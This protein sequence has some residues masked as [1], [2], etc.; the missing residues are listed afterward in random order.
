MRTLTAD[1]LVVLGAQDPEM[2]AIEAALSQADIQFAYAAVGPTRCGAGS[3][4]AADS[5]IRIDRNG[6]VSPALVLPSQPLVFVECRLNQFPFVGRID[7]HHE[8]DPGFACSPADY[9]SGSSLGQTLQALGQTPDSTQR[10]LCAADHCLTAAYQGLCPGVD[11][12]ELL[13]M[14]AAWRAL[15]SKQPLD[16]VIGLIL[17]S[18][19]RIE[20]RFDPS[21][22]EAVFLDPTETPAEL[23]EGAAYAGLPVRYRTLSGQ[24]GHQKECLKGASSPRIQAFIDQH[25][26]AGRRAYGNP[27][28]GYAGV[29][30]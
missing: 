20:D 10:L 28:R 5:V 14:R 9:L 26:A 3:A 30:L 18:A 24:G 21:A 22:G 19:K 16:H 2:R 13:F 17:D 11:P 25:R 8:G 15:L 4:Y 29:Y 7:H 1:T 27:H 12:D 23:P 6:R